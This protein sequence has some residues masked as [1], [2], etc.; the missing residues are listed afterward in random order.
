VDVSSSLVPLFRQRNFA[1]LWWGQF[2][3]LTG[4]RVAYLAL[5]GMISEHTGG[6]RDPRSSWLLSALANVM[7]APVLLFAP[8]AGA[9]IDRW[10]LRR[11]VVVCDVIRATLIVL[12]PFTY[13]ASGGH[14]L[15]MYGW[16][17]LLFTTGVF[18][19]PA[20]SALTPEIVPRTQLLAA[21]T[22]LS[23]AGIAAAA[24]GSLAGGWMVDRW[25][26][27]RALILNGVTYGLSALALSAIRYDPARHE[28]HSASPTLRGYLSEVREGWSAVR[29]SATIGMALVTLAAVWLA[30]GFLHV[31][32]NLH[33][34]NVA[35]SPGM[36]RLGVLLGVLGMGAAVS[37]AWLNTRGGRRRPAV[38]LA[39]TLCVAGLGLL[40]FALSTHFAMLAVAAFLVGLG[41]APALM[42]TETALQVATEPGLRGRVFATR[43]FLMR[44]ALLASVS[45]AGAMTRAV[46]ARPALLVCAAIVAAVGT[47]VAA[48]AR[49]QPAAA[50]SVAPGEHLDESALAQARPGGG[51]QQAQGRQDRAEND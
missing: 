21:N 3:S 34:Q 22:W 23:A 12:I 13:V 36:G 32:G 14:L 47:A 44:S 41:A 16:L 29:A 4:E 50:P 8:F 27:S 51:G 19:L 18:F 37:A 10:N 46:G 45:L 25:G 20:K 24:L 7:V 11:V 28:A 43:D 38:L 30:G 42:V 39:A 33:I 31:A 26:W 40:V 15:P 2:V 48:W 35:R 17:F 1:A 9:W 6:F 49:R 5:V